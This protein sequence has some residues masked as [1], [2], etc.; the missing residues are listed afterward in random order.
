MRVQRPYIQQKWTKPIFAE[1]EDH[2]NC[3]LGEVRKEDEGKKE[4][5][6]INAL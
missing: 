5:N 3:L 6:T 4:S 2:T 1:Q